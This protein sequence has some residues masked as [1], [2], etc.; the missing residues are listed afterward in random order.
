MAAFFDLH[1]ITDTIHL[2]STPTVGNTIF[3][4]GVATVVFTGWSRPRAVGRGRGR[5]PWPK[6]ARRL[7]NLS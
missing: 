5:A 2:G 1:A 7:G 4:L 6:A 3:A